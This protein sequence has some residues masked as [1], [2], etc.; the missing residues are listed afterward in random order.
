MPNQPITLASGQQISPDDPNYATYQAQQIGA[1]SGQQ[2]ANNTKPANPQPNLPAPLPNKS[3]IDSNTLSTGIN[4]A[5]ISA[6][7]P[8]NNTPQISGAATS[9]LN[10][11]TT[12]NQDLQNQLDKIAGQNSN[13]Q[14]QALKDAEAQQR[15]IQTNLQNKAFNQMSSYNDQMT[16]M[17]N[18][19]IGFDSAAIKA[20][21]SQNAQALVQKKIDINN[22]IISY[23]N[24]ISQMLGGQNQTGLQSVIDGRTTAMVNKFNSQI[25]VLKAASTALDGNLNLANDLLT[26]S[27]DALQKNITQQQNFQKLI[28]DMFSGEIKNSQDTIAALD[29]QLKNVQANKATVSKLMESNPTV[30][31]KAG[32]S[33]TDSPNVVNQKLSDFYAKNPQYTP[34][35]QAW[36]K[37][38]S[39]KYFDAGITPDDSIATAQAKILNSNSYKNEQFANQ[40]NRKISGYTYDQNGNLVQD[41][42]NSTADQIAD[43]IKQVESGGDYNAKGASGENGAYQFMPGTW[44]QWSSQYASQVMG[45]S[46]AQLPMTPDNQDAVAKWKIQQWLNQGYTPDQIAVIWN[47]GSYDPNWQ[48]LVGK[49]NQGVQYDVPG[50]VNKVMTALRASNNSQPG[51]TSYNQYGLLAN[52]DFNPSNE[53]DK[54][55]KNYLD[56]YIKNAAF[57]TYYTL[58]GRTTQKGGPSLSDIQARAQQLFFNATGQSLP[59]VT[60]LKSNKDLVSSNNKLANNLSLQEQTVKA[61]VDLSLQN[62]NQNGLNSSGFKPLDDLI[63]TVRNYLQDPSVGQFLSQNATIQNELGS[64]LAVKNATGTTVYDK[65]LSAGIIS[66]DDSPE[67]VKQKI[68]TMMQEAGNFATAI[69]NVNNNLWPQ[70]DPLQTD[71]N[72][73][74]RQTGQNNQNNKPLTDGYSG[75]TSSGLKFTVISAGGSPSNSNNNSSYPNWKSPYSS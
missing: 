71:P 22:Q 13:D 58:F 10:E 27:S 36:L 17:R 50:Y 52:T 73:P 48:N 70:I 25:N 56:Y 43:A 49:N 45:Q 68:D 38:A 9:A 11:A 47:H 63:D 20:A 35:N 72:N 33:L 69:K 55:A 6:N 29:E 64:L 40:Y 51:D 28:S 8:T 31:V 5:G 46:V 4:N 23:S 26:N 19:V 66:K 39:D 3:I 75:A 2:A 15:D 53:V 1:A 14:E 24:Q 44:A 62:M 21:S 61:N 41:V 32:I 30:V 12:Q 37:A 59:D 74:N 67:V 65:L 57:P 16:G 34:E 7:L 60:I 54:A 42:S 18:D